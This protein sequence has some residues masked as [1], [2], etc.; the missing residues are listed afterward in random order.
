MSKVS[1]RMTGLANKVEAQM[2][3]FI[4]NE[5]A[6]HIKIEGELDLAAQEQFSE[7]LA[8]LSSTPGDI[9]IN[10]GGKIGRAHV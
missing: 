7:I 5:E 1:G 8:R 3:N 10:L 4:V 6:R 9:M 2:I